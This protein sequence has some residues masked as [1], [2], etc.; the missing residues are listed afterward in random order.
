[1]VSPEARLPDAL[2]ADVLDRLG[3]PVPGTD[4]EGLAALYAAWCRGVPW[5]NVQKRISVA[6]RR[7]VLAGA[8]PEEFLR[9]FLAHGTGG[10]CW[11]SSGALHALLAALGFDARRA[12]AAMMYDRVG[13]VPNH[14]TEIVR[15]D[16]E[17]WL[18]DSS[19]LCERPLALRHGERTAIDDALHPMR[20]EPNDD[21]MWL[22]TW[23]AH[24]RDEQIACW[25]FED[26]VPQARFLERYEV[27]RVSGFSYGLIFRRNLA[28]GVLS[29]N[30]T[31]RAFKD[32]QGTLATREVADRAAILIGEGGL[33]PEIV[34]RL[35]DD[36][37]DPARSPG[38][39]QSA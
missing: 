28:D 34:G 24:A 3:T 29:L 26:D 1:M 38:P 12:V 35:P 33:S 16:G 21:G 20:A 14:A 25:L 18:V 9:N 17:E 8:E 13:R 32:R 36:E 23:A 7:P 30:R 2:V 6:E 5:D 37:P 19:M 4:L 27:S 11:P 31:T 22:V 39:S 15:A 10:T